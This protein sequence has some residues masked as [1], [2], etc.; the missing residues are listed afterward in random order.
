MQDIRVDFIEKTFGLAGQ[1]TSIRYTENGH[2]LASPIEKV[3]QVS[4]IIIHHEGMS[5]DKDE[6]DEAIIRR[7]YKSHTLSKQW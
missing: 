4:R 1:V 6:T 5:L 3:K 7:I 2:P